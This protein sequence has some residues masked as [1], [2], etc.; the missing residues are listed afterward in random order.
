MLVS[1]HEF[2][3]ATIARIRERILN[4]SS[5]TRSALSREVCEW[6]DWRTH[7]GRPKVVNCRV[8]LNKLERRGFLELPA[9][10]Q[11]FFGRVGNLAKAAHTWVEVQSTQQELGRVWLVPVDGGQPAQ[12]R[13]WWAMMKAH[14]PQGGGL[15]CGAQIRYLIA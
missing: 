15:L 4:D 3:D 12:S 11:V 7:D 8:A 9:A 1:G 5:L 6:L 2:S 14:H 10:R 13:L